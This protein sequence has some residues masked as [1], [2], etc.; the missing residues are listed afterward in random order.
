MIRLMGYAMS[1]SRAA[2]AGLM[3]LLAGVL[4]AEIRIGIVGTDTSHALQFAKLL[5]GDGPDRVS[6]ARI[7]AAYKGGSPDIPNSANRV[8][9]FAAELAS[10]YGVALCE[11]IEEVVAQA[12]AIMILS[13]DGRRHLEQARKVFPSGKP[14]FVDKPV[15]ASVADAVKRCCASDQEWKN[16]DPPQSGACRER[17]LTDRLRS[18]RIT[19]I[20]SGMGFIRSRRCTPSWA[21]GA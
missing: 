5:Q 6:G 4:S 14:V 8:D 16:F 13:L 15:A 2:V 20:C 18:N 7:V 19:R 1:L 9:G 12:D 17:F 10:T 21:R 3:M 11:T